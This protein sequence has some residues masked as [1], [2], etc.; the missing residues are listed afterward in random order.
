MS[1]ATT[2]GGDSL[3]DLHEVETD[4]VHGAIRASF[5]AAAA[6]PEARLFETDATMDYDIFLAALPDADLRAAWACRCCRRFVE[7]FGGLVCIG[8]D[9]SS[10]P[11]MWGAPAPDR[12]AKAFDAMARR[13]RT[14]AITAPFHSPEKVWG[15]PRTPDPRRGKVW[16]HMAVEQP[17]AMR[18]RARGLK[19]A[20]QVMAEQREG[21]KRVN[22]AL[23]DFPPKVVAEALRILKLEAVYRSEKFVGPVH[24]LHDLHTAQEATPRGTAG[25]HTRRR[26]LVWKA[27]AAAPEGYS[28]I[29][30]SVVGSLLEDVALALDGG[31][32]V[33]D[34]QARF[35]AKVGA[36]DYQRPKAA[37]AA[38]NIAEAEKLVAALGLGPALER[39]F[40]RLDDC[41]TI[42]TPAAPAAAKP[43]G[44]FG[45]IKP[46]GAV[47]SEGELNIPPVTMTWEKFAR[48]VLPSA[49]G[50]EYLTPWGNGHFITLTTATHA[51]APP[52][53]K[54]DREEER[55]PVAWYCW[56]DGGTPKRYGLPPGCWVQATAVVPLPTLWGSRPMPFLHE[57][58]VLVLEGAADREAPGHGLFPEFLRPDLL[59]IRATL[60]AYDKKAK[61]SGGAEASACGVD[62]RKGK[63]RPFMLRVKAGGATSTYQI[64]RWD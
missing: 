55:N 32:S 57:G 35:N 18:F 26:N 56:H 29:R 20:E 11:A 33:K 24:W 7:K 3:A 64:D 51:D 53:L 22:Q 47:P 5:A 43:A 52:I 54:W 63:A 31:F 36:L 21:F 15:T 48:T 38:G 62:I 41:Q 23:S 9:G 58:V 60:E 45:H 10:I 49:Q 6:S 14:G 12:F 13:A 17:A 19:T 34:I 30:G 39:R 42:W 40:A 25:G 27:V 50:I 37:P 46:K 44:L 8:E 59:P 4:F 28:H 1:Q 2:S 16:T 61:L